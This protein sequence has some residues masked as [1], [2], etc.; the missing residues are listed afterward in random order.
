VGHHEERD[1]RH[2]S[3]S[4]TWN[5]LNLVR[6]AAGEEAVVRLVER[7]G[8]G[9]TQAE[10]EDDANWVSFDEGRRL[11]E[12]AT[13]ILDDPRAL[14]KV[15]VAIARRDMTSEVVELLRQLGGPGEVLRHIDQVVPKFC[16]VVQ[17]EAIE[18]A[19]DYARVSGT[20]VPGFP[21]FAHLCDFTI[22]L[23]EQAPIPFDLPPAAV[24]EDECEQRGDRRCLFT[25]R[26]ETEPSNLPEYRVAALEAELEVLS[27][28]FETF[29]DTAADLVGVADV[30]SLLANITSRARLA[31]RAPKHVLAVRPTPDAE[32]AIHHEGCTASE[33]AALV[34]ELMADD[35]SDRDGS[36]L[37]VEV[38][39]VRQAESYGRLAAIYDEGVRFFPAERSVLAGYARL[40][41]AALDTATALEES[42]RQTE[43]AQALLDLA[44]G[45]AGIGRS[46][47]MAERLAAS[48]PAVTA[49]DAAVVML[50]NEEDRALE[51]AAT[52]GLPAGIEA[53]VQ[54][55]RISTADTPML[56][57]LIAH[58]RSLLVDTE[59][60]DPF[61]A[62]LLAA[63]GMQRAW[64]API[65]AGETVLGVLA[66]SFLAAVTTPGAAPDEHLLA[67]LDGLADIAATAFQNAKL[68]EHM[69]HQAMFDPVTQLPNKRMLEDRVE[70]A[71]ARNRRVGEG[72]ALFFL[73]LDRF[74]NVNDTLG[75][76]AGDELLR[77][78][79][80]RLLVTMREED[81]VARLGGDEFAL[82]LPRVDNVALARAIAE[83]LYAALQRPFALGGQQVFITSSIGIALAPEDGADHDTLLKN[84][85]MAMYQ[86]KEQ[87]R[88]RFGFYTP[89]LHADL[90]ARL[91][92]E[93]DLHVALQRDELFLEFQPLVSLADGRRIVGVEALVR[94][95]HPEL[96]RLMPDAF[97]GLAEDTGLI[98]DVDGW[99]IETAARQ[100][101]A[102]ARHGFNP[103]MAVNL[104]DRDLR[105]P[106][107]VSRVASILA[108]THL[109]P[110][111]LE[112][113]VTE[114]VVD[115]APDHLLA[116]LRDL[117]ALGVKIAID[118]FG[119]G[120]S[121][122]SR[123]RTFP[124]DTLKIDRSFVHEVVNA[125]D[126]APLLAAMIRLA[127]DLGMSVVAEGVETEVQAA[128]LV[129]HGCDVGQGYLFAR[130]QLAGDVLRLPRQAEGDGRAA[131]A[132]AG[133]R[134]RA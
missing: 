6:R 66:A 65:V 94:W 106:S 14:R 128:F 4:L 57:E 118:D 23:L 34:D 112:L 69:R 101:R 1:D 120:H 38:A 68:V 21:R 115:E 8:I 30:A 2:I 12:A 63:V 125:G 19:D 81:T 42:R 17:M 98:V 24:V 126:P 86:S 127:H 59:S 111:C 124:V 51:V 92:L 121:G 41:A 58:P 79:A 60:A 55:I 71:L 104:A 67:R 18:I 77:Q 62:G 117:K 10:L 114:R 72:F 16:T 102:W 27:T 83:R 20:S 130:P 54:P 108:A 7:A 88:N 22:G 84:A 73:D 96:G 25:V 97:I 85:D 56:A 109:S 100:A 107:L 133:D 105:D 37:I 5:V 99:V 13:E 32:L 132:R 103:H 90:S 44:R 75:H 76:A 39:S 49:C 28:R 47:E 61:I 110:E 36:R 53:L 131:E 82:L 74:K 29:H 26:W 122:L 91:K 123:L 129:E 45:L 119:T 40:A 15:G 11:F 33:L 64:I 52:E 35:P 70:E 93:S 9:R 48:V 31:V 113:E 3:G 50:W 95:Q 116:T 80:D 46:Q 43:T 134:E 87:G 78:V 89:A